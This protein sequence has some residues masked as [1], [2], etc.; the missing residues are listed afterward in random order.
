[1]EGIQGLLSLPQSLNVLLTSPM[2]MGF[3]AIHARF[4][5]RDKPPT[6]WPAEPTGSA[7]LPDVIN[8]P[9]VCRNHGTTASQRLNRHGILTADGLGSAFVRQPGLVEVW[10][11]PK[12]TGLCISPLPHRQRFRAIDCRHENTD[13]QSPPGRV[14][15][16]RLELL[17]SLGTIKREVNMDF[18]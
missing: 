4:A 11:S 16:V 2:A 8:P 6:S 13:T 15:R 7:S 14:V 1:M 3:P 5:G 17:P 9:T 10:K 12:K 18:N